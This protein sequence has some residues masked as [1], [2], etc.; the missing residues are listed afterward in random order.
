MLFHAAGMSVTLRQ[1]P[2][3]Q[4]LSPQILRDVD[5]WI[6]EQITAPT[7]PAVSRFGTRRVRTSTTDAMLTTAIAA[8]LGMSIVRIVARVPQS[9]PEVDAA[10]RRAMSP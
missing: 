2:C 3:A 7:D 8:R 6:I 5:R 10:P 9:G 4:E 1:Y